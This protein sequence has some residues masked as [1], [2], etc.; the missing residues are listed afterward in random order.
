M[1][2]FTSGFAADLNGMIDFKTTLG[3]AE[4]TFMDRSK[5]FDYSC[6]R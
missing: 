2:D 1:R 4:R 3:Y 6:R 5:Q